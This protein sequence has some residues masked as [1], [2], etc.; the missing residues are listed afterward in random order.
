M[1]RFVDRDRAADWSNGLQETVSGT[2]FWARAWECARGRGRPVREVGQRS[3]NN[4]THTGGAAGRVVSETASRTRRPK[5]VY[6]PFSVPRIDA[7]GEVARSPESARDIRTRADGRE[8]WPP[9]RR[10]LLS[11][12]LSRCV[13]VARDGRRGASA[14]ANQLRP[15][16]RSRS[17]TRTP[18]ETA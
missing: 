18:G 5:V 15:P 8:A 4:H 9:P 14:A 12:S 16:S 6:A 13:R 7:Y 3:R 11:G 17:L 2:S 10:S 1:S